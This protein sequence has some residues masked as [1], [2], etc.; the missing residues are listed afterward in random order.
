M[1]NKVA[2]TDVV[3]L[4]AIVALF[5]VCVERG[6][7]DQ[8]INT[9]FLFVLGEKDDAPAVECNRYSDWMNARPCARGHLRLVR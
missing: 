9:P 7:R 4:D 1:Y 5:P 3:P 8:Y 6:E 2:K